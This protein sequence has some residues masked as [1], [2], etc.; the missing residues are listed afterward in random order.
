MAD[1]TNKHTE[2]KGVQ[3]QAR[4]RRAQRRVAGMPLDDPMEKLSPTGKK[5]LLAA[6]QL[7]RKGGLQALSVEA[8]ARQAHVH[9]S[10]IAYHFGDKA[11]LISMVTD[12]LI[13]D[14]DVH[15]VT[16]LQ[17]MPVG[18]ER[19]RALL[20]IHRKIAA[21]P[22][23]WRTTL[24][25][26]PMILHDRKLHA[27]F[28]ELVEWYWEV[29][30]RGLG[31]WDDD[32][33]QPDMEIVASLMLAVLEGFALQREL[34]PRGYDLEARFAL[35]QSVAVPLIV[36]ITRQKSQDA[37]ETADAKESESPLA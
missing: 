18:E 15:I 3:S 33:E 1:P 28:A 27:R 17:R 37:Y 19:T 12:S 29:T 25:L 34:H 7:L 20:D 14:V 4:S 22:H 26:L 36:E 5:I 35:W 24:D 21:D 32:Q 31:L 23:Y 6:R 13:R 2:E 9:K 10:S 30:L 11:G 8:I 16:E